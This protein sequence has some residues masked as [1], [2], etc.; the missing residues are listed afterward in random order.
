MAERL[1]IYCGYFYLIL[2]RM[3]DYVILC[4]NL[5]IWQGLRISDFE[6]DEGNSFHLQLVHRIGPEEAE[7]VFANNPL[8]TTL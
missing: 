6:W 7:E 2:K 4:M 8:F 3:K 5:N 1:L